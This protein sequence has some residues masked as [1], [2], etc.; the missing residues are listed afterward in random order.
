[1]SSG[2]LDPDLP[3]EWEDWNDFR[4]QASNLRVGKAI[5]DATW[6][7][8]I[9]QLERAGVTTETVEAGLVLRREVDGA[10]RYYA[11]PKSFDSESYIGHLVFGSL[12]RTLLTEAEYEKFFDG[13]YLAL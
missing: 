13:W 5:N 10:L 4:A 9:A 2:P 11:L 7:Q 3:E 12:V 6:G 8:V 1:V